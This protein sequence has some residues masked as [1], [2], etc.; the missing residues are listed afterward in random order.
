V[1]GGREI[2]KEERQGWAAFA[3]EC[4]QWRAVHE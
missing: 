4:W 2:E 3:F 1:Y